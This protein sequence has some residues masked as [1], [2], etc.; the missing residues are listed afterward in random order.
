M[1]DDRMIGSSRGHGGSVRDAIACANR[2]RGP[3]HTHNRC[4]EAAH[5]GRGQSDDQ[6]ATGG[7]AHVA[8]RSRAPTGHVDRD[9]RTIAAGRR[10]RAP[11]DDPGQDTHDSS[12][13]NARRGAI[14]CVTGRVRGRPRV[15]SAALRA[16]P[17]WSP[18][19]TPPGRPVV[20]DGQV[21]PG[22]G[23]PLRPGADRSV[24]P[25]ASHKSGHT[26]QVTQGRSLGQVAH[27]RSRAAGHWGQVTAA[28]SRDT[29]IR[30]MHRKPRLTTI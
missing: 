5:L 11:T 8:V 15:H 3:G 28:V 17:G 4:G 29:R 14:A 30:H 20:S 22:T 16:D 1:E 27:A 25:G 19:T 23:G 12:G 26:S 24:R 6:T 2:P 21:W 7:A 9:T 13:G 18:H 10:S